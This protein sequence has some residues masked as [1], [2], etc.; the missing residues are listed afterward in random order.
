[1]NYNVSMCGGFVE[2]AKIDI[3]NED[4]KTIHFPH[5]QKKRKKRRYLPFFLR[6]KF[7]ASLMLICM[8]S[9][10]FISM[11]AT[12][13]TAF[14]K[15]DESDYSEA[16][17]RMMYAPFSKITEE[18][19]IYQ[20]DYNGSPISFYYLDAVTN[21]EI[22]EHEEWINIIPSWLESPFK[23]IEGALQRYINGINNL[24]FEMNMYL[25]T[26]LISVI[27]FAFEF[28]IIQKMLRVVE[29]SIISLVGISN[30]KFVGGLGTDG[31]GLFGVFLEVIFM[32]MIIMVFYNIVINRKL[33]GSLNVILRVVLSLTIALLFFSNYSTVLSSLHD[34]AKNTTSLVVNDVGDGITQGVANVTSDSSTDSFVSGLFATDDVVAKGNEGRPM[35]RLIWNIFVERPYAYSQFGSADIGNTLSKERFEEMLSYIPNT[36]ERTS[37]L[38]ETEISDHKNA[39][40]HA[41]QVFN[42]MGFLGVVLMVNTL[43]AIPIF[44]V[45][46]AIVLLQFWYII[47]AI[48]A[49][50]ALLLGAIPTMHKVLLRYGLELIIPLFLRIFLTSLLLLLLALTSL[51]FEFAQAI[52]SN[53]EG[54]PFFISYFATAIF[55]LMLFLMTFLLRNRLKDIFSKGS[56]FLGELRDATGDMTGMMGSGF[57]GLTTG[58]GA[59]AGAVAGGLA[60]GG[61]GAMAGALK[62]AN[63]GKA[64]G[65]L[66][67]G[68]GDAV[69]TATQLYQLN[70]MD[71][72]AKGRD[73]NNPD[74]DVFDGSVNGADYIASNK[75]TPN[76]AQDS[77]NTNK[78]S[79]QLLLEDSNT[80]YDATD[81]KK[82]QGV[83]IDAEYEELENLEDHDE[84]DGE[85]HTIQD[86]L[87]EGNDSEQPELVSLENLEKESQP[88]HQPL[89]QEHN[90]ENEHEDTN[91]NQ[92]EENDTATNTEGK[93]E[94]NE[95]AKN[96]SPSVDSKIE[97]KKDEDSTL[98]QLESED[99]NQNTSNP[100]TQSETAVE[101]NSLT[102]GTGINE[103]EVASTIENEST[104]THNL[105]ELNEKSVE[106]NPSTS[107][108]TG[109]N[110][111][112]PLPTEIQGSEL[113]S[114]SSEE[115]SSSGTSLDGSAIN[116]NGLHEGEIHS[117]NA[118]EVSSET[119]SMQ[120]SEINNGDVNDTSIKS[121]D[122]NP[123]SVSGGSKSSNEPLSNEI[124]ANDMMGQNLGSKEGKSSDI[125][126]RSQDNVN[127]IKGASM[128]SSNLDNNSI[129]PTEPQSNNVRIDND[130]QAQ[131]ATKNQSNFNTPSPQEDIRNSVQNG[132]GVIDNASNNLRNLQNNNS[133]GEN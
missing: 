16:M 87:D 6:K 65:N 84:H 54:T 23:T 121:S 92:L 100:H 1:M 79:S 59:M 62:G 57:R 111:L 3:K 91:L 40:V 52:G 88:L 38:I 82:G 32:M 132:H 124:K 25:S 113:S 13:S 41:D 39:M 107:N 125:Q 14:A 96:T 9:F 133:T 131:K 123:T 108:G 106:S 12:P 66:A 78:E 18:Y 126:S 71:N 81:S 44:L 130:N 86:E 64:V 7:I 53:E 76:N 4:S 72:L 2:K 90:P 42:K 26:A 110:G 69:R 15:D 94:S 109:E 97:S 28:D 56:S 74:E 118:Q 75:E 58:A 68:N 29:P 19:A 93:S 36:E 119:P 115:Q 50:F 98:A 47:V 63:M 60:T 20:G 103:S 129:K 70:Q 10:Y 128:N 8:L 99:S 77:S 67:T 31:G 114:N 30:G 24:I 51:S 37:Y 80:I 17:I 73:N 117:N 22:E 101:T 122:V 27:G 104:D 48:L 112:E 33:L 61:A 120:T 95:I 5:L 11:V 45:A 46:L 49:P 83:V 55:I 127:N 21:V 34:I 85:G 89:E 105:N 35:K 43:T 116:N 102:S